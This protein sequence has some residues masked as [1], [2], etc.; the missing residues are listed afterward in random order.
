M[1]RAEFRVVS[2]A[3]NTCVKVSERLMSGEAREDFP[4]IASLVSCA[5]KID[6]TLTEAS[7]HSSDEGTDTGSCF[8]R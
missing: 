4:L 7:I 3:L 6:L 2:A 5:A 8:Y 1:L